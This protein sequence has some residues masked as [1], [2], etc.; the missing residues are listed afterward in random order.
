MVVALFVSETSDSLLVLLLSQTLTSPP[1]FTSSALPSSP[2]F[3]V[4]V[5]PAYVYAREGYH[6]P[7][8]KV[9]ASSTPSYNHGVT[10]GH[11]H[12]THARY[13]AP[14]RFQGNKPISY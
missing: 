6:I 1:R 8:L 9:D 3:L 10:G 12:A 14:R 2:L 11:P 13:S 7:F 5:C 4:D